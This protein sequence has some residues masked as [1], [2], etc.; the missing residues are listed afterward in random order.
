METARRRPGQRVYGAS[1]SF[2]ERFATEGPLRPPR[3]AQDGPTLPKDGGI[4][5]TPEGFPD[6]LEYDA[7]NG[8]QRVGSAGT[9]VSRVAV[10]FQCLHHCSLAA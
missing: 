1:S 5:A 6:T 8:R 7:T 3:V 9:F 10:E 2:G 4:L